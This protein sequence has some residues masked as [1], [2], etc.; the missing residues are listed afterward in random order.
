MIKQVMPFWLF[1]CTS[2][3]EP[4]LARLPSLSLWGRWRGARTHSSDNSARAKMAAD[5][6][7]CEL[8]YTKMIRVNP[9]TY[10]RKYWQYC[11]FG[12]DVGA[13]YLNL[14]GHGAFCF[15]PGFRKLRGVHPR[16]IW[17]VRMEQKDTKRSRHGIPNG[18][19]MMQNDLPTHNQTTQAFFTVI[20]NPRKSR[21]S[22]L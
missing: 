11:D 6:F 8:F 2:I 15:R 5:G 19:K 10:H 3:L 20:V 18:A 22:V 9:P 16:A 17:D 21:I 1:L 4:D 7:C 12:S 13:V 14:S